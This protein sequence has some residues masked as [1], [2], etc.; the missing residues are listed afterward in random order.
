MLEINS[1]QKIQ[2]ID[3]DVTETEFEGKIV[4]LHI[5]NGEYYN[6]NETGSD[7]WN[8]LVEVKTLEQLLTLITEKYSVTVEECRQDI[9][10]WLNEALARKLIKIVN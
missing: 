7:L 9:I 1:A 5:E 10:T 3:K 2:R 8:W 4:L 6:F